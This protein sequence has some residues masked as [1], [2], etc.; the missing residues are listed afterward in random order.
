[1]EEELSIMMMK[2]KKSFVAVLPQK[3]HSHKKAIDKLVLAFNIVG[4]KKSN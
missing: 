2:P 4:F 1:M 3:Y